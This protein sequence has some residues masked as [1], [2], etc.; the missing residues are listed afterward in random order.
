MENLNDFAKQLEKIDKQ[1]LYI[2][3][4]E[5][6]SHYL[7]DKS[8]INLNKLKLVKKFIEE[9]NLNNDHEVKKNIERNIKNNYIHILN[10]I[11]Q[12]LLMNYLINKNIFIIKMIL[13]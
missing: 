11:I 9:Y 5:I 12:I 4:N 10:M 3:F 6:K 1:Q 13:I 2:T 8:D 7:N